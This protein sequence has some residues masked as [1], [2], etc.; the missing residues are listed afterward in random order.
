MTVFSLEGS[1]QRLVNKMVYCTK[2]GTKNEDNAELCANC[3]EPLKTTRAVRR[4]RRRKEDDCFGLPNGGSIIGLIIGFIII[5]WGVS[6]VLDFD[7][8]SYL[9]A[10]IIV[11]FGTLL[12][13]GSLYSMNR[14]R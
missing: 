3:K 9:W 6:S 11:I 10:I 2:C 14:R 1:Q 8:G 5:L 7:F 13:A 4:E 12:V